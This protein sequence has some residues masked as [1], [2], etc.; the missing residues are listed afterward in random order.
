MWFGTEHACVLIGGGVW[1]WGRNQQGEVGIGNKT[2]Q[3]TPVQVPGLTAGVKTMTTG[4]FHT[5]AAPGTGGVKCWGW[6]HMAAVG[7]GTTNVMS[8]TKPTPVVGLDPAKVVDRLFAGY[9]HTCAVYPGGELKCWGWN[10]HGQLGNGTTTTA[11]SA[12]AVPALTSGVVSGVG[13]YRH[14]CVLMTG[15]TVKCWGDNSEGQLGDGSKTTRKTPVDVPGLTNVVALSAG[16]LTTCAVTQ[17]GAV[18]CWG[19]N[20]RGTVGD[21]TFTGRTT[22]TPVHGLGSG[23]TAISVRFQ[24]CALLQDKS[25]R[26]WGDNSTGAFGDG[27]LDHHV[28]PV[29]ITARP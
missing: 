3:P 15:G 1:C 23:V 29:V 28:L 11:A 10:S 2:M 22:P 7:D 21:M 17:S 14:T 12:I 5:C 8:V 9:S 4:L 13:G 27:L 20:G 18:T 19:Y 25:V 26:C 6:N 24:A 16:E